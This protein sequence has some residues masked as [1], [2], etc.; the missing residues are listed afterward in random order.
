MKKLITGILTVALAL[1]MSVSVFAAEAAVVEFDG[2]KLKTSGDYSLDVSKLE[3][4]DETSVT[5]TAKTT[6]AVQT[7]WYV[8]ASVLK[9]LEDLEEAS[10][11]A[12][13][14]NLEYNG[15]A[16]VRSMVG[17]E[18][19]EGVSSQS[20]EKPAGLYDV[21]LDGYVYLGTMGQ[22]GSCELKLTVKYDGKTIKNNYMTAKSEISIDFAVEVKEGH[23]TKIVKTGNT[24]NTWMYETAGVVALL[25]IGY[26]LIQAK[27]DKKE[28]SAV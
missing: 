4:G 28:K 8:D 14:Y 6:G 26:V 24:D 21:D 1:S 10:G 7:D 3:P 22:G 9:A 12:Y 5:I 11:G 19:A 2:A 23:T 27:Y 13:R 20:G 16:I 15:K 17:G 18:E 25:G